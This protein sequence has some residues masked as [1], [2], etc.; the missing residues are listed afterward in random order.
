MKKKL[1][2]ALAISV[3]MFGMVTTSRAIA[4]TL[5][6]DDVTTG[7]VA[8]PLQSVAPDYG[9]LTWNE[10]W[11][12]VKGSYRP[13]SGYENGVVSGEYVAYY[14]AHPVTITGATFNFDGAYLTSSWL[15]S[16]GIL[17][18]GYAGG[19]LL[20]SQTVQTL[21]SQPTWFDFNYTGVDKLKFFA[22]NDNN[23][24]M[25]NFTFNNSNPVPEP[26]T[27]LLFGTGIAGL[28]A[29]IIRRKKK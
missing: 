22:D 8:Y 2:T 1:L 11:G 29:T 10:Y 17:V 24:A 18:E 13:G 28:A 3:L 19:N 7:N 5:T 26:A 21:K 9:G 27:M 6:F 25:D 12:V 15:D 23:F 4:T 16:L 20:Y 14:G